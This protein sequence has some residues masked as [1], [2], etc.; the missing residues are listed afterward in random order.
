M[1]LKLFLLFTIIPVVELYI[2]FRL[3]VYIGFLPT[4]AIV[5]ITGFAGAYL[6]RQQGLVVIRRLQQEVQEG[7]PPGNS[8]VDGVLILVAGIVLLTPGILT[9]ACGILL[10]IPPTRILVR[11]YIKTVIKR[12]L[13]SGRIHVRK[14]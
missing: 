11:E 4:L 2:L 13:D 7:H 1:L 8:I 12:K 10:L 5:I 9:D 3:A 6:A 14:M